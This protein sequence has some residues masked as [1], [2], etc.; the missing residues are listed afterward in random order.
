VHPGELVV[1]IGA[2]TGRITEELLRRGA[3][4][5][6]VELDPLLAGRLARRLANDRR[7]T[8]VEGDARLTEL[9]SDPFR[10]VANLP[11][12]GVGALQDRLF[13]DP[14]VPLQRADVVAEWGVALK[15]ASVWPSTLR[16]AYWA[17]WF[18]TTIDRRLPAA[19][20]EP[21]PSVD[22]GVLRIERRPTPLVPVADAAA[23]RRFVAAGFSAP[24]LRDALRGFLSPRELRRLADGLAFGREAAAPTLDAHQ[25]AALFAAT[26][27]LRYREARPS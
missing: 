15:R 10:V 5:I 26:V 7:V 20:F 21:A 4:V 22:A 14:R 17:A 6:A 25:W 23:Y 8:V 1:D 19:L 24:R 11:F 12:A 3:R 18:R 9:P 13:G 27:S 2:G 16:G